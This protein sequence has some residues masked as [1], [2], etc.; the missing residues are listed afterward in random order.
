MIRNFSKDNT[1]IKDLTGYVLKREEHP[2]AYLV[3]DQILKKGLRK[4]G[5]ENQ[6]GN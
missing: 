2:E 3:I 6:S 1:E 5:E 4:H